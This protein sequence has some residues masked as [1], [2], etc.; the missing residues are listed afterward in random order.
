MI[1][2]DTEGVQLN[3]NHPENIANS[4]H[5]EQLVLLSDTTISLRSY[6]NNNNVCINIEACNKCFISSF[7]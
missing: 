7:P 6:L 5:L 3:D 2:E 1:K 4:Y